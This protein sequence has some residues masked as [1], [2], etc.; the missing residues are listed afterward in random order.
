M[1]DQTHSSN[2]KAIRTIGFRKDQ[3]RIIP[4]DQNLKYPSTSLKMKLQ[5]TV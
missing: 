5:K 4:T 1:S 3:I 2:I